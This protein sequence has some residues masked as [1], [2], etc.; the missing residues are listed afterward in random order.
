VQLVCLS[1]HD[2]GASSSPSALAVFSPPTCPRRPVRNAAARPRVG[3]ACVIRLRERVTLR[4]LAGK[5]LFF[6]RHCGR[7]PARVVRPLLEPLATAVFHG[8][9]EAG[10]APS[11]SPHLSCRPVFFA[12]PSVETAFCHGRRTTD[13]GYSTCREGA[14][15]R[16]STLVSYAALCVC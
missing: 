14:H 8:Q 1:A 15:G 3:S 16:I 13:P 11:P 9:I 12:R 5:P 2:C 4:C 7:G 10:L 6:F